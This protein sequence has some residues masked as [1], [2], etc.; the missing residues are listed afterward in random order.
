M[1]RKIKIALRPG[2][3]LAEGYANRR[4]NYKVV[5]TEY[6]LGYVVSGGGRESAAA[7]YP[8]YRATIHIKVGKTWHVVSSY[9]QGQRLNDF[10][11]QE[12]LE[13]CSLASIAAQAVGALVERQRIRD[14]SQKHAKTPAKRR[15]RRRE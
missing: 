9:E 13:G 15:S 1:T 10:S 8:I 2:E 7:I 5:E 6:A 3:I 14:R 4:D 11:F 12:D